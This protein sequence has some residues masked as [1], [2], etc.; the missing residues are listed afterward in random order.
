MTT[1]AARKHNK[2]ERGIARALGITDA[3]LDALLRIRQG[4]WPGTA[5]DALRKRG[6]AIKGEGYIDGADNVRHHQSCLTAA[7]EELLARARQLGF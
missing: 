5:A 4:Y 3:M 6:Y 2:H 1:L 7:G